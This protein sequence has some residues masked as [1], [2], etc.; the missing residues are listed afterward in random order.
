MASQAVVTAVMLWHVRKDTILFNRIQFWKKTPLPYFIIMVK[1]GFP[2]AVQ[3]TI[4]CGIS[5]ILHQI[6]DRMGRYGCGG[7]ESRRPD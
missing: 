2:A 3:E 5:M 7:A 4:Y 1:I 6:C